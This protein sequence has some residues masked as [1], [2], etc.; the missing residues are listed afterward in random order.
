MFYSHHLDLD[1][2]KTILQKYYVRQSDT[3]NQYFDFREDGFYRTLH[4]KVAN[5]FK[6][7]DNSPTLSMNLTFIITL[8]S[9]IF[10]FAMTCI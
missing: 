1:K 8:F 5:H 6:T 9:F 2:C 7:H 10:T 3:I 4:K